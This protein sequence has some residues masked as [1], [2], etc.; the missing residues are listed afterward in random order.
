MKGMKIELKTS[1]VKHST[2]VQ[3]N[4]LGNVLFVFLL[5]T[6]HA[7]TTLMFVQYGEYYNQQLVSFT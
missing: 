7:E 3:F 5:N 4:I 6:E 2:S 1:V